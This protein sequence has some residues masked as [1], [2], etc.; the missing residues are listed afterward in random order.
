MALSI[1]A[2]K[3]LQ[4]DGIAEHGKISAPNTPKL[5]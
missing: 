1:S 4:R 3:A 2:A 5:R